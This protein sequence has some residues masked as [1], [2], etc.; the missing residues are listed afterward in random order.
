MSAEIKVK[1]FLMIVLC[2]E[3]GNRITHFT[4]VAVLTAFVVGAVL[5]SA[6]PNATLLPIAGALVAGLLVGCV[7]YRFEFPKQ[8]TLLRYNERRCNVEI[9][10]DP[11]PPRQP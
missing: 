5:K 4:W 3:L 1:R 8:Q 9:L 10:S 7:V 6:A 11:P 2:G